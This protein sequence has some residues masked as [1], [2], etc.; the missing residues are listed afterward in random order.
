[1]AQTGLAKGSSKGSWSIGEG[2]PWN[3]RP[4]WTKCLSGITRRGSFV[5]PVL[6][7]VLG[8]ECL[9]IEALFAQVT[10]QYRYRTMGDHHPFGA[11]LADGPEQAR[12]VGVVGQHEAAV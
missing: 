2:F 9:R 12:P 11:G 5:G 7:A 3:E 6:V 4:L 8:L 10:H 1:M